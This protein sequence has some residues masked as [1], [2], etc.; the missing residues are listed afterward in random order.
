MGRHPPAPCTGRRKTGNEGFEAACAKCPALRVLSL[1]VTDH[2]CKR[3]ARYAFPHL[4]R[5]ELTCE[6][7]KLAYDPDEELPS[8]DEEGD[9]SG[10][11]GGGD[12]YCAPGWPAWLRRRRWDLRAAAPNLRASACKGHPAHHLLRGV[13]GHTA[14]RELDVST[15]YWRGGRL[16]ERHVGLGVAPAV[17]PGGRHAAAAVGPGLQNHG[18]R[19]PLA[20]LG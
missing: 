13:A 14:L 9:S 12:Y 10:S 2:D 3:R 1:G 11:D 4:T 5:L 20:P 6:V 16:I 18:R 7:S 19:L 17:A 15:C 8:S